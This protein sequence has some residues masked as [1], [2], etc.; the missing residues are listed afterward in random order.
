[1]SIPKF[2]LILRMP[3]DLTSDNLGIELCYNSDDDGLIPIIKLDSTMT[4][5]LSRQKTAEEIFI[6]VTLRL[7]IFHL[8]KTG[9]VA[10]Y[11]GF[12]ASSAYD[13]EQFGWLFV[14]FRD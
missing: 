9:N 3:F 12:A 4:M 10:I 2:L 8:Q 11:V 13:V 1:M 6:S 14:P 5:K 7:L